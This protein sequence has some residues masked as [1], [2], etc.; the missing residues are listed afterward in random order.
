MTDAFDPLITKCGRAESNSGKGF[1]PETL[2]QHQQDCPTCN[3]HAWLKFQYETITG[4]AWE[5]PIGADE[6][7]PDGAYWALMAE[8][9]GLFP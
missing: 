9:N 7:T 1:T 8:Q 3:P 4:E 5:D 6:D 2:K